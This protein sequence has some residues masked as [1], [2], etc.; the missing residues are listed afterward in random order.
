MLD[1]LNSSFELNLRLVVT[2]CYSKPLCQLR[3]A[4]TGFQLSP[5]YRV[6]SWSTK[7]DA[8]AGVSCT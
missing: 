2:W 4:V 5:V 7:I 6:L 8:E 1:Y 3:L